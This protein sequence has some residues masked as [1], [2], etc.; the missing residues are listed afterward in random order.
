M[1]FASLTK[2]LILTFFSNG[3]SC[4]RLG[5]G[6]HTHALLPAL[7]QTNVQGAA[8]VLTDTRPCLLPTHT[9]VD[10][11]S[12]STALAGSRFGEALLD[13]EAGSWV[14][15]AAW[16]PGGST[17]AFCCQ[18]ATLTLLPGIDLAQPGSLAAARRQRVQLLGLPLKCLAFLSESVLAG[19]G[20]DFR[21]LLVAQQGAGEWQLVSLQRGEP[22]RQRCTCVHCR[23]A[24]G[25]APQAC[26]LPR[27]LLCDR[28]SQF[29]CLG[30]VL[31]HATCRRLAARSAAGPS[32]AE[33][34]PGFPD[35]DV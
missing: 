10:G 26:M 17:L 12:S 4:G 7:L 22:G 30:H 2:R 32:R 25:R 9:D 23:H 15:A 13:V 21:P 18:D 11:P 8:P 24:A 19:G 3:S 27:L 16:S 28:P 6:L 34:L 1:R 20:F 31:L 29:R 14:L 5:R 35:P 33:L